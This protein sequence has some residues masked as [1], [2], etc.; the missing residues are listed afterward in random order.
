M[1]FHP[2]HRCE[3][4][5]RPLKRIVIKICPE[6][7]C[8]RKRKAGAGSMKRNGEEV[9]GMI[10]DIKEVARR[11]RE[12]REIAGVSLESLAAELSLPLAE[13]R[14]FEHGDSDI[15]LGVL[16]KIANYFHIELSSLLTGEEPRL[17]IY[18]IVRKGKG[19]KVERR[20]EYDHESLGFNFVHKKAE[21]FLVTVQPEAV[22][23]PFARNAHPGQEFNY[24]LQG[25]LKLRIGSHEV[26]LNEGD[27]L[28]F[29]SSYEHGMKAM[30]NAPVRFLAIIL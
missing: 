4:E 25:T 5:F 16:Y 14:Q 2:N 28:F 19:V 7:S 18:S 30:N 9:S 26:V 13:Y 8:S 27:A 21:P 11:I 20:K 1:K 3:Q 6:V 10:D 22:E 24:V 17:H 12:I 23:T 29:D 15:P